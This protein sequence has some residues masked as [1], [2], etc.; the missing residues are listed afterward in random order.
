MLAFFWISVFFSPIVDCGGVFLRVEQFICPL[1]FAALLLNHRRKR[2]NSTGAKA[3]LVYAAISVG[4][5]LMAW[6]LTAYFNFV[7]AVRWPAVIAL[8]V[9]A[10]Y[11]VAWCTRLSPDQLCARSLKMLQWLLFAA[12]LIGVLQYA[13]WKR[14]LPTQAV[15]SA[16]AKYYPYQG[17]LADSELRKTRDLRLKMGSTGR[18]TSV[19]DGQPN[20]AADCL[21]LGLLL[22]LPLARRLKGIILYA[23]PTLALFLTLSRGSIIGWM[24]GVLVYFTLLW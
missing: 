22:T 13:E 24:F 17:E 16:L 12:G 6:L 7:Y 14:Y 5:G 9:I 21:A 8:N 19:F 11:S 18:V 20:R 15:N 10:G 4:A 3:F 2:L 1:V 23:V